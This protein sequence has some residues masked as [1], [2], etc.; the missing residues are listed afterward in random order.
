MHNGTVV[1]VQTTVI[2]TET[3]KKEIDNTRNAVP[4]T[5][6]DLHKSPR[7]KTMKHQNYI[8]R[9]QVWLR[10]TTLL[11]KLLPL[12]VLWVS[13]GP[14]GVAL[15]VLSRSLLP[16]PLLGLVRAICPWP[17]SFKF[18]LFTWC[19]RWRRVACIASISS[20]S[21]NTNSL[22]SIGWR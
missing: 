11:D 14:L 21:W 15:A 16:P 4:C 7:H 22:S 13:S 6:I 20:S 18:E 1:H 5:I 19:S 17:G 9:S 10:E 2:Y 3:N 8:A 12:E